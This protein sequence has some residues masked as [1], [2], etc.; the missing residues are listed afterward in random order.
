MLRPSKQL[1][2]PR[3]AAVMIGQAPLGIDADR[4]IGCAAEHP[5]VLEELVVSA[6]HV[7]PAPGCCEPAAS[8]RQGS[9]SEVG[10]EPGGAEVEWVRHEECSVLVQGAES[11]ASVIGVH[12]ARLA[13]LPERRKQAAS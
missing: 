8:R 6:G 7:S 5:D 11:G 12:A 2:G 13:C 9:E 3:D 10:Q 1:H 4:Q